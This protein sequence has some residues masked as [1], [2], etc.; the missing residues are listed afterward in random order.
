MQRTAIAFT[1]SMTIGPADSNPQHRTRPRAFLDYRK[2]RR[3]RCLGRAQNL[4]VACQR[5]EAV[6]DVDDKAGNGFAIV[7][8]KLGGRDLWSTLPPG[9]G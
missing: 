2:C 4:G 9:V 6:L 7:I 8:R 1:W 5:L 3:D